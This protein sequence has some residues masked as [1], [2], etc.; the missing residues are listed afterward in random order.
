MP[1][2]SRAD[3]RIVFMCL[4]MNRFVVSLVVAVVAATGVAGTNGVMVVRHPK[5]VK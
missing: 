2:P 1:P 5:G 4:Q 3:R